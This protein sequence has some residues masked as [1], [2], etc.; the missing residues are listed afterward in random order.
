[1]NPLF[2]L[3]FTWSC[4]E[5]MEV[6][7]VSSSRDCL[8]FSFV[9]VV[10]LKLSWSNE[11]VAIVWENRRFREKG[12]SDR[13]LL[14]HLSFGFWFWGKDLVL[15]FGFLR[16]ERSYRFLSFLLETCCHCW[17]LSLLLS[18]SHLISQCVRVF[19][20]P[21]LFLLS[22]CTALSS[23]LL[24]KGFPLFGFLILDVQSILILFTYKF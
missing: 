5:E 6:R 3:V 1:M 19:D 12:T 2:W 13:L 11:W 18:L 4:K 20:T 17:D 14:S 22:L 23:I 16:R 15:I 24:F 10:G 21:L 9:V 8:G 7:V